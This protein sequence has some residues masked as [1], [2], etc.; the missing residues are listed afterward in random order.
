LHCTVLIT[1]IYLFFEKHFLIFDIEKPIRYSASRDR[2]AARL[3]AMTNWSPKIILKTG[4]VSATALFYT[5]NGQTATPIMD[6][7][8]LTRKYS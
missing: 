7:S 3:A 6:A 5:G 2:A 1:I 4:S 8:L